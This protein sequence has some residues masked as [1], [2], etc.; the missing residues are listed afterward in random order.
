MIFICLICFK[1]VEFEIFA[2]VWNGT[3]YLFFLNIREITQ[4]YVDSQLMAI[5]IISH[6]MC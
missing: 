2:V 4:F 6:T 3:G 1:S 5:R